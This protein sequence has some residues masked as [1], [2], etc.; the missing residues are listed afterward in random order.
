MTVHRGGT[1]GTHSVNVPRG[2]SRSGRS[3]R[4]LTRN[5]PMTCPQARTSRGRVTTTSCTLPE[6]VPHCGHAAGAVTSAHTVS[7]P[8]ASRSAPVT[9]TPSIPSSTVPVSWASAGPLFMI[10]TNQ[11]HRTRAPMTREA[12]RAKAQ[13]PGHDPPTALLHGNGP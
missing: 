5:K 7:R 8:S 11:D 2:Q 3:S 10:V 1:C 13:L 12:T 6:G 4:R 9:R